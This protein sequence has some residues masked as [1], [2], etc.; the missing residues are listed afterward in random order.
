M[1]NFKSERFFFKDMLPIYV[2]IVKSENDVYAL[3]TSNDLFCRLAPNGKFHPD[4]DPIMENFCQLSTAPGGT[5]WVG[6]S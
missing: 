1:K 6:E 5:A 4:G 2:P 3:T